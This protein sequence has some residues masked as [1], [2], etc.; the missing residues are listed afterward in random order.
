MELTDI[1]RDVQK[2]R[3]KIGELRR[4]TLD[5]MYFDADGTTKVLD[6]E[7]LKALTAEITK[8]EG[9]LDHSSQILAKWSALLG[10]RKVADIETSK[11]Y[12]QNRIIGIRAKVWHGLMEMLVPK[13]EIEQSIRGDLIFIQA[14]KDLVSQVLKS[15]EFEELKTKAEPELETWQETISDCSKLL[16][17][18]SAILQDKQPPKTKKQ[19]SPTINFDVDRLC[20]KPRT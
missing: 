6:P 17:S 18:F 10:E 9:Q 7:R 3:S 15:A 11:V 13:I 14:G 2:Y 1:E 8:F 20:T 16:E 12:A 5:C 19:Q 4:Q